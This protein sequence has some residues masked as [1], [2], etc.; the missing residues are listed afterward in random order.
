MFQ[1]L[2]KSLFGEATPDLKA[3]AKANDPHAINADL[4]CHSIVS[5]GTLTPTELAQRAKVNGVQIWSMTDHDEVSG[6]RE[7]QAAAAALDLSYVPGVEISVTWAH[8]T[9]HILG[10]QIDPANEALVHGLARTRAGRAE[11]AQEMGDQLAAVGIPGAF[12]GAKY[13]AGNPELI[14]RTHFARYLVEQNHCDG[15]REVFMKYLV[16]GKPGY[17]PMDWAKL[18]AAVRWIVDAGGTAIVA[19]P[20][21]YKLSEL[22]M[23]AFLNQFREFG[24][25]GLEVVTG[26]HT[27]DQY[28]K[29]AQLTKKYGFV[30]SRGSDFHGPE[31]SRVDLGRLPPLPDSVVPVWHTW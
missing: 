12:E 11:R 2:K 7:A 1:A 21:R 29:Y 16:P 28:R 3:E 24:G 6:Q 13:Y 23:D 25:T 31:E 22:E 4:H 5:D 10:L 18:E 30:A 20:G 26:S 27:V 14:S 8:E 15:V 17:V 9:I 19:H